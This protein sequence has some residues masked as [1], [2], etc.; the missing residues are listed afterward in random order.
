M[1]ID[2]VLQVLVFHRFG[3][4][5]SEKTTVKYK[6]VSYDLPTGESYGLSE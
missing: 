4:V 1:D 6:F 2:P 5:Y 3:E